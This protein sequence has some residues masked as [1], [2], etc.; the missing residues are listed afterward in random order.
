MHGDCSFFWL[1]V[2][3]SGLQCW[4]GAAGQAHDDF[5]PVGGELPVARLELGVSSLGSRPLPERFVSALY[6]A[7]SA[8]PR[9]IDGELATDEF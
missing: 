6:L 2:I 1:L 5:V 3:P 7:F 8:G 9:T 4:I